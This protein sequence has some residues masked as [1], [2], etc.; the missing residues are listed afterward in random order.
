[1]GPKISID[2]ATLMNK[3]LELIEAHWLFEELAP[4]SLEIVIHPQSVVHSMVEFVDGSIV[5]QMGRPDMR[6]PIQYALTW[7]ARRPPAFVGFDVRDFARLTF[8]PPDPERFPAVEIGPRAVRLGG[9]AGA[10]VN[11]A[12]EV[13]VERF[14]RDEIPFPAIAE[15]VAA[16]LEDSEIQPEPD[17]DDIY[18]ADRAAREEAAHCRT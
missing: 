14:L 13:A 15:T 1:M 7:P 12:N 6:V 5:A 10:I 17:L 2:S 9:T 8:E 18:A 3:A 11:A 4:E 16:V